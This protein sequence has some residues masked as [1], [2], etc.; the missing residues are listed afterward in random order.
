MVDQGAEAVD[1]TNIPTWLHDL[2]DEPWFRWLPIVVLVVLL[3]AALLVKPSLVLHLGP[4]KVL[5]LGT[6]AAALIT[7]FNRFNRWHAQ[8]EASATVLEENLTVENVE[9]IPGRPDF[10]IVE[11]GTPSGS[12]GEGADSTEAANFR[13]ALIDAHGLFA[14]GSTI[15]PTVPD[16]LDLA[17]IRTTLV[18][19]LNPLTTI[20]TR[21]LSRLGITDTLRLSLQ[22]S[23][24]PVMAYPV[25]NNPMYEPLRDISSQLMIPNLELIESNTISL[26]ETNPTFIEAYM[27][28]LNHEMN[29]ELLWREYYCDQRGS[30]FRQF[31]DVSEV[32]VDSSLS[33]EVREELLRDIPE[34][35]TWS[36]STRLG[37]HPHP[38]TDVAEEQ[39]VLVIRGDLLK[40]Y[41]NTV[42]CAQKAAW[43]TDEEGTPKKLEPRVLDDGA[44]ELLPIFTASI[45]PDIMFF[46]FDL[47]EEEA[48]GSGRTGDDPGY[49]FVLKERPGEP[50]FG[51][52][53]SAEK[54]ETWDDLSWEDIEITGDF[55][56]ATSLDLD[57]TPEPAGVEWGTSSADM[58][59][60]LYQDPVLIAIHASEM[61]TW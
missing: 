25:F 49:F 46:G 29:R 50:R 12:L 38:A 61:L 1:E 55:V 30:S 10:T 40:K 24:V 45:D 36:Q 5:V 31:W 13:T 59:S 19:A 35:H 37:E 47:T 28:G 7:L 42:I 22:E 6:V 41:P 3:L 23:F 2:L 20:P 26:L 54:R 32:A 43:S 53:I 33:D 52:D 39:L 44:G 27:V 18:T 4:L 57:F 17:S 51:L 34:I 9:S 58:A 8:S 16:Q 15:V 56:D 21:T 14:F 60:I 11:P 48:K